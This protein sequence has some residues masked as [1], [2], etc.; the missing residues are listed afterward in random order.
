MD[1]SALSGLSQSCQ[2]AL[3]QLLTSSFA[4]CADVLGLVQVGY[5]IIIHARCQGMAGTE[6]HTLV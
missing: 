1:T 5:I 4:T 6:I 2:S 3:P